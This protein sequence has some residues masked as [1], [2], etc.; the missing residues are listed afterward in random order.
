MNRS[1]IS[2]LS[3]F[4]K[5]SKPVQMNVARFSTKNVARTFIRTPITRVIPQMKQLPFGD[6]LF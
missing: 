1:A 2:L 3:A 5:A 4:T 6:Y